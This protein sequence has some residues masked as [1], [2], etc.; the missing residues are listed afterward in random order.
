MRAVP[1]ACVLAIALSSGAASADVLGISG[2]TVNPDPSVTSLDGPLSQS[3][4][5][6]SG[7]SHFDVL[8]STRN[9]V[10]RAGLGRDDLQVT[11]LSWDLT[12]TTLAG[13]PL[14]DLQIAIY[15]ADGD[16]VMFHPF[17]GMDFV[18]SAHAASGFYDL[19]A[20]GLDF[21][22]GD[23]D[24][25]VE[26]FFTRPLTMTPREG[27]YE[28]GSLITLELTPL[29]APGVLAPIGGVTLLASRR[30]RRA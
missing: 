30:R 20:M 17:V 27:I 28:D 18:G 24:V 2:L 5:D 22:L 9:Q 4:L 16:G 29:P 21:A 23:G 8:G 25:Y 19:D 14:S 11:G 1:A 10:L 3:V 13:V 7:R 15:N 6:I 26:L 12:G